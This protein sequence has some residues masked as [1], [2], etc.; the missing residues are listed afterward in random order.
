MTQRIAS[1]KRTWCRRPAL[2]RSPLWTGD[3]PA[4]R[5]SSIFAEV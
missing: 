5:P 2:P 3:A 1:L 4:R